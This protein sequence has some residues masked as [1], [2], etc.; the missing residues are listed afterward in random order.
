MFWY[1]YLAH[2]L[3]DY[4]LQTD[5][6]VELKRTWSGLMLHVFVHL[7]TMLLLVGSLRSFLWL[8]ILILTVTH[9][10]IDTLKNAIA[11]LRPA[12]IR[13]SYVFDQVLHLISVVAVASWI[14]RT[15]VMPEQV[16]SNLWPLI[17][18]GLLVATY[19]WYISER[20]ITMNS[21]AYQAE[22]IAQR[23]PR[24]WVRAG[25]FVAILGL[26]G[27]NPALPLSAGLIPYFSGQ[28]RLRALAIDIVVA[29]VCANIVLIYA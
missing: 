7:L 2:L 14:E 9:Y 20:V 16:A 12:W 28:H 21:V 17:L 18:S 5:R 25:I 13:G 26:R 6:M 19:V 11:R 24:M 3:A 29:S 27:L 23:W 22:L 15:Y 8:P 4:P 1:L 10:L